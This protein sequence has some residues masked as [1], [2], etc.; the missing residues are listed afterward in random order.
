MRTNLICGWAKGQNDKDKHE[1]IPNEPDDKATAVVLLNKLAQNMT[2]DS[3]RPN[4]DFQTQS[5]P[6]QRAPDWW[7]SARFQA[8]CVA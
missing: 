1:S 4:I 5:H 2:A 7:E 3:A 6:T 8:L